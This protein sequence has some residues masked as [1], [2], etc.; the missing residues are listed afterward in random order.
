MPYTRFDGVADYQAALLQIIQRATSELAV[1]DFNLA[2]MRLESP[3]MHA[4]LADFLAD[5]SPRHVRIAIHH[6]S[7]LLTRMPRLVDLMRRHTH[8]I[9]VRQTPDA[10]R[11]LADCHLLADACN[12]V[13]RFHVDHARGSLILD[14][15]PEI[16]PWW[17]RFEEL[18]DQCR[19]VSVAATG[20]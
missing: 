12:G 5:P 7:L 17:N 16:R 4:A 20:L 14:D 2:D 19:P 15:F 6:T 3:A 18:W 9:E 1:F 8:R 11:H 10:Y 13:R